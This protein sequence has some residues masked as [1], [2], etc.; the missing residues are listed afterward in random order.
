MTRKPIS[1]KLAEEILSKKDP[2]TGKAFID[3]VNESE[4]AYVTVKGK[5]GLIQDVPIWLIRTDKRLSLTDPP[6]KK[7]TVKTDPKPDGK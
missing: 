6:K 7:E 3:P 2:V 5:V 1:R 4:V